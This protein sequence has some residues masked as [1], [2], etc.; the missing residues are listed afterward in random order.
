MKIEIEPHIKGEA[1][2]MLAAA[3][4]C[5]AFGVGS[6]LIRSD[7]MFLIFTLC[8][9]GV[10]IAA[11]LR[12]CLGCRAVITEDGIQ[13]QPSFRFRQHDFKWK[14]VQEWS[15]KRN[16]NEYDEDA[17]WEFIKLILKD[18]TTKTL[19]GPFHHQAIKAE[20]ARR[21]GVPTSVD[22]ALKGLFCWQDDES[23]NGDP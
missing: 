23:L 11:P 18:G 15:W 4:A 21:V 8:G 2:F 1:R 12:W 3:V 5:I 9:A 19:T 13:F 10:A 6:W 16:E 17:E 7:P 20:L 22:L 14:E